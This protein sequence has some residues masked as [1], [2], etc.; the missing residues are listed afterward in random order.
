MI[1]TENG[2]GWFKLLLSIMSGKN[3]ATN[4]FENCPPEYLQTSMVVFFR[5]TALYS[6]LDQWYVDTRAWTNIKLSI[7]ISYSIYKEK[8]NDN[9]V[10][11]YHH[12]R[13]RKSI[14][15]CTFKWPIL[16]VII[17]NI[18]FTRVIESEWCICCAF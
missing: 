8:K 2:H 16:C 5:I 3:M 6:P 14:G 1:F 15:K 12:M 10:H 13:E 18:K 7:R 9:P 4:S 17:D 11:P